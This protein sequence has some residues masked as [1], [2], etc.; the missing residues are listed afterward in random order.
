[1]DLFQIESTIYLVIL[2]GALVVSVFA[3]VNSL[4]Y[5]SDEYLA[6]DKQ[7][8]TTWNVILGIGVLLFFVP[9]GLF[10]IKLIAFVAALVYLVDVRPAMRGLTRR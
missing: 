1:M 6:A 4:L 3:F 2:L 5:R 10:L 7:T 9:V 8:K